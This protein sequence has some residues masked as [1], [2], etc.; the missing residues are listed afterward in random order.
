MARKGQFKKGGGRVGSATRSRKRGGALVRTRTR[1]ITKYKTRRAPVAR[2]R[3]SYRRGGAGRG[4]VTAGKIAVT[5]VGLGALLSQNLGPAPV[6]TF[7][8]KV[9]GTKT[10]GSVAIAGLG[11]GAIGHFTSWGGRFRP[12]LKAAGV[13]GIV[14]AGVKLGTDNTGFKFV[15]DEYDDD[16]DSLMDVDAD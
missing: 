8:D 16:D 6:R 4:G 11:L 3:R 1:T 14:A 7:M 9:P 12:W 13:V 5:A 2:R 15:G 10:F